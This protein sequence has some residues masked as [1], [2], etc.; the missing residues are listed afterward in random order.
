MSTSRRAARPSMT[1]C[2]SWRRR[3]AA[4]PAWWTSARRASAAR[5]AVPLLAP[6]TLA[7]TTQALIQREGR[8]SSLVKRNH[9]FAL[10][11]I[12][13][14]RPHGLAPLPAL[15]WRPEGLVG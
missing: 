9:H 13:S 8:T 2:T 6:T 10:A 1:G 15:R 12:P 3:R 7:P 11:I 5:L 14:Q 4:A